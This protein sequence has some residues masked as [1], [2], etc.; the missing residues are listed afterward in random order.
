MKTGNLVAPDAG[1]AATERGAGAQRLGS[2]RQY[3]ADRGGGPIVVIDR[4]E[5]ARSYLVRCLQ[6]V[7]D[8]ANIVAFANV[9]QWFQVAPR[10]KR[11]K[12]ILICTSDHDDPGGEITQD[13]PPRETFAD[14]PVF[15]VPNTDE[16]G[17]AR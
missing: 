7:A 11:P 5:P 16:T 3:I 4:C 10:Y 12:V 9:N 8:D 1:I 2:D 13:L 6:E 14:V 15:L 17:S